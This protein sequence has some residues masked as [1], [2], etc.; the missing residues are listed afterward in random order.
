MTLKILITPTALTFKELTDK[1]HMELSKLY[2]L[3]N[4]GDGDYT[5]HGTR[6]ELFNVLLNLSFNH[7]IE[8]V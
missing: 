3:E 7:D 6:E 2:K 5:I 8:I 4:E 1:E